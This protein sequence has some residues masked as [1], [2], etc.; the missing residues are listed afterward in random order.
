MNNIPGWLNDTG[1]NDK[2]GAEFDAAVKVVGAPKVFDQAKKEI[3]WG[4]S[5]EQWTDFFVRL[6]NSAP[7]PMKEKTREKGT[8]ANCGCSD[9]WVEDYGGNSIYIYSEVRILCDVC[10][11]TFLSRATSGQSSQLTQ[12]EIWIMKS[13]A[14]LFNGLFRSIDYDTSELGKEESDD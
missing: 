12:G 8:C 10:A 9:V 3:A 13:I 6:I 1:W 5:D 2:H 7:P 4:F 14:I 11:S